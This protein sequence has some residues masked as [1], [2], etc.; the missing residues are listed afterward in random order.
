MIA[1]CLDAIQS[2]KATGADIEVAPVPAN[3][4][5]ICADP[6]KGIVQ[7]VADNQSKALGKVISKC[8]GTFGPDTETATNA[9]SPHLD[10]GSCR[11]QEM[12]GATYSSALEDIAVVVF[13]DDE[14]A[15]EGAFPCIGETQGETTPE[16]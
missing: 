8:V 4:A 9:L 14:E 6:T 11:A 13:S 10:M 16:E 7:R 15:A 1:K 2:W 3:V 12:I 5:K